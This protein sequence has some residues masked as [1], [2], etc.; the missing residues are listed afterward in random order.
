MEDR[1]GDRDRSSSNNVVE[2]D[3]DKSSNNMA[4]CDIIYITPPS[5]INNDNISHTKINNQSHISN[6]NTYEDTLN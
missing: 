6:N 2:A 4:V 3:T 5:N 1:I